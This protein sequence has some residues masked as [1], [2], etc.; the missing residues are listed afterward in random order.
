MK[1]LAANCKHGRRL[2]CAAGTFTGHN[3]FVTKE[4]V[5]FRKKAIQKKAILGQEEFTGTKKIGTVSY[6]S[7]GA[8]NS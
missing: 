5:S 7:A 2:A 6:F 1:I 8:Q 4:T 3:C